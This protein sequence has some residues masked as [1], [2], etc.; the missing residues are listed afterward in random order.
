MCNISFHYA[1]IFWVFKDPILLRSP[2]SHFLLHVHLQNPL[3]YFPTHPRLPL[4]RCRRNN[5]QWCSPNVYFFNMVFF[6]NWL[7]NHLLCYPP[8]R[9]MPNLGHLHTYG[10]QS[11]SNICLSI[12]VILQSNNAANR[13]HLKVVKDTH[14]NCETFHNYSSIAWQIK[15]P[16]FP[17]GLG[18]LCS[19]SQSRGRHKVI[20]FF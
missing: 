9:L 13:M 3:P 19:L 11:F 10:C 1:I 6:G 16:K 7:L 4:L 2:K 12:W 17:N 8:L 5:L 15:S 20:S 14:C 18:F